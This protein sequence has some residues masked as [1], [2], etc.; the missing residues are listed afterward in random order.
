[1]VK[2]SESSASASWAE[3]GLAVGPRGIRPGCVGPGRALPR[4]CGAEVGTSAA[5]ALRLAWHELDGVC[6]V[7]L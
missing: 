2:G 5:S 3:R 7:I 4:V 1:M 6:E